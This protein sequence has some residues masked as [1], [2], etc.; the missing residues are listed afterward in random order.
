VVC[1]ASHAVLMPVLYALL[2]FG[3]LRDRRWRSSSGRWPPMSGG[4]AERDGV[5]SA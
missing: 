2:L 1:G 3:I 4:A 5:A